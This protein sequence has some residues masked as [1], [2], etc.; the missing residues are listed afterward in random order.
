MK[1]WQAWL[2]AFATLALGACG[3]WVYNKLWVFSDPIV[4]FRWRDQLI[5]TVAHLTWH[6]IELMIRVAALSA[7]V[8]FGLSVVL[9]NC[10]FVAL[11]NWA[12]RKLAQGRRT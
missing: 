6:D 2:L 10:L 12:K 4:Q 1:R 3:M 7:C 5:N 11:G 8:V 9:F